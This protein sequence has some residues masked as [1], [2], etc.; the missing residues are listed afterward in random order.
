[1]EAALRPS[2]APTRVLVADDEP[3]FVEMVT[4]MLSAEG[5]EVVGTARDGEEAVEKTLEFGPDVTLMDI[6]MPVLDGIE[7]T[8][9]IR[10]Q[11]PTACVLV[12]TGSTAPA[13]VDRA[14]KAGASAFLSK[15]RI[16]AELVSTIS[17]LAR[18]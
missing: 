12:L 11:S 2:S 3:L 4:A 15:D 1:M 17:D 13:E 7:A 9:R 6:S 8:R 10:D 5:M 18:R 16:A 14:R